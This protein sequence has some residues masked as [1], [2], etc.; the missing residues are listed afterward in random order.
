[1]SRCGRPA[2]R[3]VSRPVCANEITPALSVDRK[4]LG[5]STI[6]PHPARSV[7]AVAPHDPPHSADACRSAIGR[8]IRGKAKTETSKICEAMPP[9]SPRQQYLSAS[10]C[11]CLHRRRRLRMPNALSPRIDSVPGSGTATNV[12]SWNVCTCPNWPVTLAENSVEYT[13]RNPGF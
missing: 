10:P 2:R 9:P 13:L 4:L 7:P 12:A 5:I 8:P 1:M 6:G 11:R 3:A